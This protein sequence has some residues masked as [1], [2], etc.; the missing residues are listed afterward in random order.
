[1]K[2]RINTEFAEI[3]C[4]SKRLGLKE[5]EL[6]LNASGNRKNTFLDL[7]K[8]E[9]NRVLQ[10]LREHETKRNLVWVAILYAYELG[11]IESIAYRCLA[12]NIT[13][14]NNHLVDA[15]IIEKPFNELNLQEFER[16]VNHFRLLFQMTNG[17]ASQTTKN[18]SSQITP[19]Q[20]KWLNTLVSNLH[21]SKNDKA[22]MVNGFSGG[23]TTSSKDLL[24]NE[25]NEMINHLK[26]FDTTERMRK[27]VFALAYEAGIIYGE[28]GDD[29][30]I[31]PVKLNL[32]LLE[33][34]TIK[35]EL[36]KMSINELVKVVSQFEQIVKHSRQTSANKAAK[37]LLEELNIPVTN[38]RLKS[39]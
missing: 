27:K 22:T 3:E 32:F 17:G 20:L 6:S 38:A 30:K 8:D 25:A 29:K 23:R 21:I 10:Q 34:G 26:G 5:A 14:I 35:K 19:E 4:L 28:T 31:N 15:G 9:R 12:S 36:N 2:S 24:S 33:R 37:S 7:N 16:A 39:R 13:K 18:L 1:M 11:L